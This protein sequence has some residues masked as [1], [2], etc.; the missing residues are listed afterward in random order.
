MTNPTHLAHL[1]QGI[2]AWNAWRS[3]SG[4]R[5]DLQHAPLGG[6]NLGGFNFAGADCR[7][8]VFSKSD[9]SG[10]EFAG[11]NLAFADLRETRLT[12]AVFSSA[13][14]FRGKLNGV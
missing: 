4:V 6:M 14:L 10:C 13:S 7:N 5:P 9:L 8:A 3:S 12:G 11:A 1:D 2:D